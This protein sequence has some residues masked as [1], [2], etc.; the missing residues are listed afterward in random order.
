VENV[1]S[2]TANQKLKTHVTQTASII[3]CFA[4]NSAAVMD[5][6]ASMNMNNY[7][8]QVMV[9]VD[10]HAAT[11]EEA[12]GLAIAAV[13]TVIEE[14]PLEPHPKPFWVSG[15]VRTDGESALPGYMVFKGILIE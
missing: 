3:Q 7:R 6:S 9:G 14:D 1:K 10:V 15:I 8:V 11:P 13:R 5:R 4:D 12:S 2:A